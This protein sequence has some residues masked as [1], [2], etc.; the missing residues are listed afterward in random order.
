ML[1]EGHKPQP[2]GLWHPRVRMGTAS[3][4]YGFILGYRFF[5]L[6]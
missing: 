3:R 6:D 5:A 2:F 1:S 4:L